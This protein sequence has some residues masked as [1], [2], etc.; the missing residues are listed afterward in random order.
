MKALKPSPVDYAVVGARGITNLIPVLGPIVAELLGTVIP[1]QR[2][3]RVAKYVAELEL[4]IG[5]LEDNISDEQLQDEEVADL[6]HDGLQQAARSLSD[7]RRRYIATLIASGL[8]PEG[9]EVA[10]SKYLLGIL[11]QISDVE[12]VWLRSYRETTMGGDREFRKTQE[13]VL[14]PVVVYPYSSQEVMRKAVLQERYK[15]HLAELGLLQ[16]RPTA[17]DEINPVSRAAEVIEYSLTPFGRLLLK[18]IGLAGD[19]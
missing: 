16:R 14:A 5:N 6:F 10:E 8:K 2:L 15:A 7:E 3:D 12:I 18:E 13:I 19:E 9:I 4:R 1:N 11:D 17:T